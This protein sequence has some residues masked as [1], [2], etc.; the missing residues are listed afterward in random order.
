[1]DAL[2]SELVRL[3]AQEPRVFR[4]ALQC[5]TDSYGHFCSIYATLN[6]AIYV[7]A[8]VGFCE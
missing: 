2:S 6:I 3:L 7:T 4:I 8:L 1:M 5:L